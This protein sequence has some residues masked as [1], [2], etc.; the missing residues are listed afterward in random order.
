MIRS[1]AVDLQ[2]IHSSD[3]LSVIFQR[4]KQADLIMNEK[5]DSSVVC[6]SI[7]LV[8]GLVLTMTTEP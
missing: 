4:W 6:A 1:L 5:E 7:L 8:N 2:T 3:S